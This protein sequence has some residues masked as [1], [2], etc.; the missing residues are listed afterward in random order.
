MA[1][2][3]LLEFYP[4]SKRPIDERAAT[5]TEADRE[6]SRQF[7]KDYFDGDRKHGY[8]GF[9][10]HPRFWQSTVRHLQ[11]H[12]GLPPNARILDIGCGKGFMLHDFK[13]LMP[14]AFVAGIDVSEYAVANT[15]ESMRPYVR[16][17]DAKNLAFADRSFDLVTAINTIHN[18]PPAECMQALKEIQRV[19]RGNSFITVD[20]WRTAEERDR[21]FRWV[22]TAK[23]MM[24]VDD[25]K[26]LFTEAGY[27]GDYY[28]FIAE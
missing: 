5:V 23:T 8:G 3:N 14:D 27:T 25:W 21:L 11:N 12:Y 9:S 24:H 28:W 26:Q 7:G 19:S 2:I 20:A 16:V 1:E 10:Y 15:I 4:R 6:L 18:L 22:L 17:G 13:E